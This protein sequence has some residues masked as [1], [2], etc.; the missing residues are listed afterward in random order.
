MHYVIRR[1]A[2]NVILNE[3]V[4]PFLDDAQTIRATKD[5]ITTAE[6]VELIRVPNA[7]KV[8]DVYDV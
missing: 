4:F 6:D 5:D 8:G 3:Y 7:V 2:D 1:K